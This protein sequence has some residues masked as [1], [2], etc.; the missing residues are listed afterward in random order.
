MPPRDRDKGCKI[1]NIAVHAVMP[2]DDEERVA[3][4]W[5][6]LGQDLVG[7]IGIEMSERHP[8]RA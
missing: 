3:L 7:G 6:R 4:A 2:L 5:T 1:G 8:P